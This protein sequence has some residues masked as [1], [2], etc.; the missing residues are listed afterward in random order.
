MLKKRIKR[1]TTMGGRA[2]RRLGEIKS[3]I[4]ALGDEDLLDLV[5][6]FSDEM[7]TPL[8]EIASAEMR[9]RNISL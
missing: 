8:W 6:I 7:K 1:R 2:A 9:K 5:D 3:S 4:T